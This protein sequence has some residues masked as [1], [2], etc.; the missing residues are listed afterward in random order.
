MFSWLLSLFSGGFFSSIFTSI[1]NLTK[2]ISDEK[3]AQITAT[4]DVEKANIQAKIDQLQSQRD[5]LIADSTSKTGWI[6]QA[7]RVLLT[8]PIIVY[9]NKLITWDKVIG[10]WPTFE[11]DKLGSSEMYLLYAVL[12]FFFLY[13]TAKIFK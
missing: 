13:S 8:L 12:G 4:T 7:I 5:V 6:D 3:I 10:S 9:L 1:D 11:T 2:A